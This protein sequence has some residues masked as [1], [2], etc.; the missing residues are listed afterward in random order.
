MAKEEY[1]C[2]HYMSSLAVVIMNKK[3][4]REKRMTSVL[5]EMREEDRRTK[6]PTTNLHAP[7]YLAGYS[8]HASEP[9]N[10][11]WG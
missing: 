8:M 10:Q 11:H 4:Q 1:M 3:L 7:P 2:K 9:S 6:K 5:M